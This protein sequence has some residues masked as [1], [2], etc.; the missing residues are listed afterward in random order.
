MS[1]IVYSLYALHSLYSPYSPYSPYSTSVYGS[2][3][4]KEHL[5]RELVQVR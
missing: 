5:A 4:G 2:Q 3:P 1:I